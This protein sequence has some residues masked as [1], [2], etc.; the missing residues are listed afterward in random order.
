MDAS[1]HRHLV[2]T[3]AVEF[4]ELADELATVLEGYSVSRA[5]QALDDALRLAHTIK[6]SASIVG[7]AELA[8]LAHQL[9][10]ALKAQESGP[11]DPGLEE[12]L[13]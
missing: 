4:Q 10:E 1:E 5:R 2:E 13:L 8:K 12:R 7:N 11:P 9:E 3:F 6:G